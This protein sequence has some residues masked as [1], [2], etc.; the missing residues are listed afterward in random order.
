MSEN[1]NNS[2]YL[3][4]YPK[5]RKLSE[6]EIIAELENLG[7]EECGF[8]CP[9]CGTELLERGI[10]L[11]DGLWGDDDLTETE[12]HCPYCGYSDVSYD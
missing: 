10:S 9:H 12:R 8:M 4:H 11:G 6:V 5:G 2:E 7:F 1:G 3:G